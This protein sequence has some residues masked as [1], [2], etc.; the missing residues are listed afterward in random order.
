MIE[1]PK[2]PNC[3][4]ELVVE[5]TNALRCQQ[6]GHQFDQVRHPIAEAARKRKEEGWKSWKRKET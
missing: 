5:I 2:C 3:G 4:S 6:C 1:K